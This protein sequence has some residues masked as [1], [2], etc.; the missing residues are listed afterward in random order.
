MKGAN[1]VEAAHSQQTLA[2][3]AM[4]CVRLLDN[5]PLVLFTSCASFA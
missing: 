2:F 4:F 5:W 3:S 1:K